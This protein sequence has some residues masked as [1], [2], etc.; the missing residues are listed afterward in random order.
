M[1]EGGGGGFEGGV[2]DQGYVG[3]DV[4]GLLGGE[5]DDAG[6]VEG[7]GGLEHEV[8][9]EL[10]LGEV[11]ADGLGP[12]GA[13]LGACEEGG[14]QGAEAGGERTMVDAE[15]GAGAWD[16]VEERPLVLQGGA[17]GGVLLEEWVDV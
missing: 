14:V 1:V 8:G 16:G 10:G 3:L 7:K 4:G 2:G 9:E 6:G 13:K 12:A 17:V 11:D 5:E 15:A